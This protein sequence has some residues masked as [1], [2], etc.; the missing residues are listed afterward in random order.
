MNVAGLALLL[1][2][3]VFPTLAAPSKSP[4]VDKDKTIIATAG[5]AAAGKLTSDDSGCQECHGADGNGEGLNK[6]STGKFAKLAGQYP[7]YIAKQLR[8]FR[9]G[10]RKNDLMAIMAKSINESEAADIAAY[11]ASQ[12]KM[13]GKA[14]ENKV[15]GDNALAKNLFSNGDPSR[16]I[17]PCASC[18]GV[19]GKGIDV[20]G[21]TIPVIGGQDRTYLEKQLQDWRSGER[22]NSL[23][24]VMNIYSKQLTD[25]ELQAL[26]TYISEL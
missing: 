26:S 13:Q 22:S 10:R 19:D 2:V 3:I 17:L 12:K 16:N 6:G 24:D 23:G 14:S 5:D 15:N 7:D 21:Q 25:T 1:C 20:P 11:F 18:H 8:D 9:S 4:A